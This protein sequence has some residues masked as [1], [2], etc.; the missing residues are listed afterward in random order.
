VDQSVD[1]P[2]EVRGGAWLAPYPELRL[3]LD[4]YL[5]AWSDFAQSFGGPGAP[6][7]PVAVVQRGGWDD[8]VGLR[9]AV[10]GDVNDAVTLFG[11]LAWEPSPVPGNRVDPGFPRGDATVYAAGMSYNFPQLSFDLGVSLHDHDDVSSDF[12]E[13]LVDPGVRGTYGSRDTVWSASAR[14]R[15]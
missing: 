8:V 7:A 2:W 10:E 11:G 14:W 3:E 4:L 9:L 5:Q 13:D 6:G 12:Q 1:L 15:F